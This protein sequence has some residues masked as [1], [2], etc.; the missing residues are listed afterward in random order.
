M[1]ANQR[2]RDGAHSFR[3]AGE[4]INTHAFEVAAIP[5]DNT[6]RS[7]VERHHYS[8]SYPA[9]LHRFGLYRGA[10]LAGVAVFSVGVNDKSLAIFPGTPRESAEL[11]RFVLLD[12]VP[13]NGETWFLARC[14]E[15]LRAEGMIGVLSLSDP[16]ARRAAD[17]R[18]IFPGHIGTIYQAHNAVYVGRATPRSLHLLP[19]GRVFSARAQQKIRARD[20]GWRYS[21]AQLEAAGARPLTATED[22]GAWLREQ[23][24]IVCR[25]FRHPGNLKYAWTLNRRDRRHLPAS[26][27]Y[28]KFEVL[29]NAA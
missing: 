10:E 22:P 6:A 19:D 9:A 18:V 26:L 1:I 7:F 27:P 14:F 20:Q 17:G 2:W 23:L 15:Q 29:K 24:P 4:T 16:V 21:A 11:G 5:D 8:G 13:G 12:A 25:R 3:P 28:P